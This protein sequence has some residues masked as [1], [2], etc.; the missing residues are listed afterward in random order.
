MYRARA[1]ERI[2]QGNLASHEELIMHIQSR[3]DAGAGSEADLLAGKSRLAKARARAI[4][5]ERTA[6]Q[7]DAAFFEVFGIAPP[8]V[9]PLPRPV[10][11]GLVRYGAAATARNA[12]LIRLDFMVNQSLYDLAALE[13]GRRPAIIAS[14]SA[15]P[16][17]ATTGLKVDVAA[18]LG[19]RFDLTN[20]GERTA[21]IEEAQA[22]VNDLKARREQAR[23]EIIRSLT[24]AQSDA[25]AGQQRIAAAEFALQAANASL[26]TTKHQFDIGRRTITEVLDAQRDANDAAVDDVDARASAVFTGYSALALTGDLLLLFDIET[27][28]AQTKDKV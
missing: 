28:T 3:V 21:K 8:G 27:G 9:V 1:L 20:G 16:N 23:R 13:A 11:P 17:V 18:N 25:K 26:S 10:A 24:Y 15:T 14:L 12:Q 19:V 22:Q 2:A 7:A 6:A 5:A 4:E